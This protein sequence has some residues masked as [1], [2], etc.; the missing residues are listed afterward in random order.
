VQSHLWG[1]WRQGAP[2]PRF[3]AS[4]TSG[5]Y[6]V[7]GPDG[8][9]S[10]LLS[11]ES[12]ASAGDRWGVEPETRWGHVLRGNRVEPAPTV[13]GEWDRFYP[14]FAFAVRG[15]EPV[16][17]DP[18]DAVATASVLDAARASARSGR[19]VHPRCW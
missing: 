4:G 1:S 14:A 3:R 5:T 11:G 8:Q 17:V 19:V 13:R 15:T 7:D 10:L 6:L 2:G 9:E 12:P 18:W 16:P